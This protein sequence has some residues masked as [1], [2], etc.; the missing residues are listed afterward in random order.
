MTAARCG[1]GHHARRLE[2]PWRRELTRLE[3]AWPMPAIFAAAL[4]AQEAVEVEAQRAERDLVRKQ[5]VAR[6]KLAAAKVRRG[7]LAP[8]ADAEAEAAAAAATTE[9]M[10]VL[11]AA[12]RSRHGVFTKLK[13]RSLSKA[14]VSSVGTAAV[15]AAGEMTVH[16]LT[17]LREDRAPYFTTGVSEGHFLNFLRDCRLLPSSL[18]FEALHGIFL[19]H[20]VHKRVR[21]AAV[22]V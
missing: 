12:K 3:R 8:D 22:F 11:A 15:I 2:L 16:D 20:C 1:S 13:R 10:A 17:A 7:S 21:G 9:A 14:R 19:R 5:A 18:T 6:L 4:R